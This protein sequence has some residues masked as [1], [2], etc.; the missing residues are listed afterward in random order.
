[1]DVILQNM[2]TYYVPCGIQILVG[3]L[4]KAWEAKEYS[5]CSSLL[6]NM[7]FYWPPCGFSIEIWKA[8]K[9][10]QQCGIAIA[11]EEQ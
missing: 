4:E 9:V 7:S 3:N 1:M 6:D 11:D 5:R 8:R 2:N 10:L